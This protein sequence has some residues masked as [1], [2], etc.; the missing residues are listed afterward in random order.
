MNKLKAHPDVAR[1]TFV[2]RCIQGHFRVP[3]D[4]GATSVFRTNLGHFRVPYSS[5]HSRLPFYLGSVVLRAI[6]GHP[7]APYYLRSLL[8]SVLSG[9]TL[10]FR[11][12]S[13]GV[14]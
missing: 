10:V 12:T 9:D 14:V 7:R 3:F 11:P 8:R 13:V 1:V 5:V 6:S 4:F 2:F